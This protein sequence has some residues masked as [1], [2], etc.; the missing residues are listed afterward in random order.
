MWRSPLQQSM[1]WI[2]LRKLLE[3][4][5][6]HIALHRHPSRH[7]KRVCEAMLNYKMQIFYIISDLSQNGITIIK[8]GTYVYTT[9]Q[10]RRFAI[11]SL[12][13]YP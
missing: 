11:D 9:N 4:G 8:S 5:H 3:S 12:L 10:G 7:C 1:Q 2:G 6:N 13:I